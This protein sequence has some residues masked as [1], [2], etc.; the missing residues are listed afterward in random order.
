MDRATP[1]RSIS[2]GRSDP[3]RPSPGPGRRRPGGPARLAGFARAGGG[4]VRPARLDTAGGR[5]ARSGQLALPVSRRGVRSDQIRPGTRR[6]G[7]R[8]PG[9]A[10][11]ARAAAGGVPSAR[12][13]QVV[14]LAPWPAW[15]H[16]SSPLRTAPQV[17]AHRC[18]PAASRPH[19][20]VT[21]ARRHFAPFQPWSKPPC[22][23]H[24]PQPRSCR[25]GSIPA[26]S[27]FTRP[28]SRL[29]TAPSGRNGRLDGRRPDDRSELARSCPSYPVV[30]A[31]GGSAGLSSPSP[32]AT[33]RSDP[34][35]RN[36][37]W[38][39]V[40]AFRSRRRST[41]R[42]AIVGSSG[43]A[44]IG[45]AAGGG[46]CPAS[47]RDPAGGSIRAGFTARSEPG[48]GR[49]RRVAREMPSQE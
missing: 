9:P 18:P 36:P 45:P 43:Q 16:A 6:G 2:A 49:P 25:T 15:S 27:P 40:G 19:P 42:G 46:R 48:W 13:G 31:Q 8:R 28:W 22:R 37:P 32:P 14:R 17:S 29:P 23:R 12:P 33:A 35:W 38:P 11:R 41:R 39:G 10:G 1:L 47:A 3:T 20:T 44:G 26:S 24:D 5:P 7:R 4:S 30:R 21:P 34:A